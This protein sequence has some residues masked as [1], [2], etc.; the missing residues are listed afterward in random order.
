MPQWEVIYINMKHEMSMSG[1]ATITS[2][3]LFGRRPAAHHRGTRTAGGPG[4]ARGSGVDVRARTARETAMKFRSVP[5]A[6]ALLLLAALCG[7]D[8]GPAAAQTAQILA[9][10]D[11]LTAGSGLPS[12]QSFPAQLE[13][14]LHA[15]R[16]DAHV[17]NAGGPGTT[18]AGGLALL[19]WSLADK[20]DLVILELGTN[21]MLGSIDP[22]DRQTSLSLA[23]QG[24]RFAVRYDR[25]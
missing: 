20:P 11:S 23:N 4:L 10:G 7:W 25:N 17:V 3:Q 19:D 14:R 1:S 12:D 18:T 5:V 15:D 22:A 2:I 24:V 6:I 13:Q 16:F 8:S 21:D 9:F